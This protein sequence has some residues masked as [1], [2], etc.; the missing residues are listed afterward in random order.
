LADRGR[1]H[2]AAPPRVLPPRSAG[3]DRRRGKGAERVHGLLGD[4][5]GQ[6]GLAGEA[7]AGLLP[8]APTEGMTSPHRSEAPSRTLTSST[9][10]KTASPGSR[11]TVP[12]PA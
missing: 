8:A 5:R 4:R 6:P 7:G 11:T 12:R 9:P 3:H 10:K 2:E 1:P